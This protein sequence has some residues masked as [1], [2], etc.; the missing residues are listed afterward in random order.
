MNNRERDQL[1]SSKDH[2]SP[3]S[4]FSQN[5]TNSGGNAFKSQS[6]SNYH[7]Q[8]GPHENDSVHGTDN[9]HRST[10]SLNRGSSRYSGNKH[11]EYS[12][13][14]RPNA[15]ASLGPPY[16]IRDHYGLTG[17]R[18]NTGDWYVGLPPGSAV[19]AHIQS[20]DLLPLGGRPPS[21]SD[22]LRRDKQRSKHGQLIQT[23][24]KQ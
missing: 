18:G 5:G 15:I 17:E 12:P 9:L 14:N 7:K 4:S 1:H 19:R 24:K 16:I 10:S 6:T 8:T 23:N 11:S 3:G 13:N 21:S 2:S 22:A 20:I